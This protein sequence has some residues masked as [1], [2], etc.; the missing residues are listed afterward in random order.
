MKKLVMIAAMVTAAC[1]WGADE[2][3]FI[4]AKTDYIGI[5]ED[6]DSF[7]IT[8]DFGSV[9]GSGKVGYYVYDGALSAAERATLI[10]ESVNKG[11][12]FTKANN[13]L[14]IS[15]LSA[16]DKIGFYLVRKNGNVISDWHFSQD[17]G[18]TNGI[19]FPK[20]GHGRDEV[21]AFAEI[22]VIRQSQDP[23]TTGMPLPGFLPALLIGG[24]GLS[25]MSWKRFRKGASSSEAKA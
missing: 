10:N 13:T 5:T 25:G 15:N 6:L 3:E 4:S 17:A 20:S 2:Y 14:T 1:V 16:G 24:C 19:V 8:S 23:G 7:S 22:V 21:L 9:G 18:S 12:Y 11:N